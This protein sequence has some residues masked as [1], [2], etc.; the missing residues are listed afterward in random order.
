MS[1]SKKA[2]VGFIGAGSFISFTH[3][4]TAEECPF[5]EIRAIADISGELL[6]RHAAEKH[7]GYTTTEYKKLLADPEIDIIVIGT[8]QDL[9]AK[10]I[11][12][13]LDAGKWVFCEKPM[14]DTQ[15][16]EK[17]VIEAEKRSPGRLAV[18]F[19]RRFAPAYT[20]ALEL[21]KSC[22]RPWQ[23]SY[24][25]METSA[26]QKTPGNFYCGRPHII[27]EGCHILDLAS[28]IFGEAPERV[29]MSGDPL[30]SNCVVLEYS[31]GSQFQFLLTTVGSVCLTKE[32]MEIFADG[33]AITVS[34]FI[35]MRVRGIPGETDMLF[36]PRFNEH[37]EEINGW[38]FDFY[39]TFLVHDLINDDMKKAPQNY[40]NPAPAVKR[41]QSALPFDIKNYPLRDN[42]QSWAMT[43]DKGWT[44][45]FEHF[46]RAFLDGTV[47]LNADASAGKLA[48]DL[49]FAL[50]KSA[51]THQTITFN[52]AHRRPGY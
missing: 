46:A 43:P 37:W 31:D 33:V 51:E 3:L 38:G 20:K 21:L 32:H 36:P 9:H 52:V 47:P 41:P 48:S 34:E 42:K 7:V 5:T 29:F 26:A 44:V 16:E 27:F 49:G 40:P 12:E 24:R 19:N 6:A 13:S 22:P 35:D 15:D 28:F 11:V 10:L 23:I 30:K 14:C 25:L 2:R 17:S 1:D 39:E 4:I 45:S 50:I 18:G 8:K